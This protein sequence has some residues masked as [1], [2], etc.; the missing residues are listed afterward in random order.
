MSD[1][2]SALEQRF[3]RAEALALA[4]GMDQIIAA[5]G[6]KLVFFDMAQSPPSDDTLLKHLLGPSGNLRAPTIRRGRCLFIGFHPEEL[7]KFLG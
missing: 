6:P 1:K 3:G 4:R 5:R 7:Q 2:A